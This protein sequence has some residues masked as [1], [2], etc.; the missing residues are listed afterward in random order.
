MPDVPH[1]SQIY[2]R[3]ERSQYYFWGGVGLILIFVGVKNVVESPSHWYS[4]ILLV[5]AWSIL[6]LWLAA[7]K[8]SIDQ[9]ILSY[10]A[11]LKGTV[12]VSRDDIINAEVRSGRFEHAIIIRPKSGTPI[13]I[14]TKPFRKSDLQ[15][16]LQFL[17]NKMVNRSD[18]VSPLA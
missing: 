15:V 13:V 10:S 7:F 14:N 4:L 2:I 11:L 6:F 8:I 3:A 17:S 12:S 1:R 5:L 16:V 9:D 18:E